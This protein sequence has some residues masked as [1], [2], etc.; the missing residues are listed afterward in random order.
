MC[1]LSN[2]EDGSESGSQ[3]DRRTS[4]IPSAS[5]HLIAR[6]SSGPTPKP[7]PSILK[8]HVRPCTVYFCYTHHRLSNAMLCNIRSRS[9]FICLH[10]AFA[11]L[12][13]LNESI[14]SCF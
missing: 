6:R 14:T 10:T 5:F 1:G 3:R 4:V 2:E 7:S 8:T 9:A 13:C 11:L 12:L